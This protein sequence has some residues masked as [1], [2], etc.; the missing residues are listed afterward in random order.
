MAGP[1]YNDV[2]FSHVQPQYKR[3]DNKCDSKLR[4]KI[5]LPGL[6]IFNRHNVRF[7]PFRLF[8]IDR[9]RIDGAIFQL[10][11]TAG[12]NGRTHAAT[13]ARRAHNVTHHAGHKSARL[14]PFRQ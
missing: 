14:Y 4:A 9:F 11:Y 13:N 6:V 8:S 1:S 5:I 10:E 12:T 2:F 3:I 7:A